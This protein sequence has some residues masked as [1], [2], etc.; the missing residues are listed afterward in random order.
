VP[1]LVFLAPI[2]TCDP[3]RPEAGAAL[4][5]DGRFVVVGD[6]ASCEAAARPGAVRVE[7]GGAVPGLADAHGHVALLGRWR[8]EL[9]LGDASGAEECAARAAARARVAPPGSWIRGSGWD[10][11]RWPGASFPSGDLLTRA[12]PDHPAAL[13]RVD[14]H[15]LWVNAAALAAAG[16]D[17]ASADPPGGR[18]LR[19]AGGRP[20]GVLLDAAQDLV[21]ARIPPPSPADLEATVVSALAHL[22]RLGLTAVHD[23]GVTPEVLAVLRRL[24]AEDRLPLRVEAMIDGAAPLPELRELME[25]A[26]RAPATGRLAVRAVKLFADGALGSRGAALE[27]DYADDPGNRGLLLLEPGALAER[28]RAIAAAGLQPA[29][30]AI[31]DRAVGATLDAFEAAA[32]DHDLRAL[33]PRIEHL[34]LVLP[35][36]LPRLVALGVVASM[37]PVHAASDGPWLAARLGAGTARLRGAFAWRSLAAAGVPLAFGSDFPVE[38]ADPRA[39]LAAAETR[40]APGAPPFQ[41]EE[42]LDRA[43]AL[44]AFTR[45]AALACFAEARRGMVREGM[46][47]DLT[48]FA[49]D[50][51]ACSADALRALPVTGTVVG[52]RLEASAGDRGAGTSRP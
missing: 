45:G 29:V 39:G 25:A 11:N 22:A 35:R 31:G 24:A 40:A 20:A 18:I 41:A 1:D 23:A 21:L 44:A 28:V 30:H 14:G 4:V 43:S 47:A 38:E 27:E 36:H 33:R 16:I 15:A 2:S 50:P 51:R 26:R 8:G 49:G 37:Q 10:Q 6:R 13:A 32:R 48:L 42:A 34:Q 12:V 9:R 5:R 52:G 17:A 3:A 7:A 46:E 19:G